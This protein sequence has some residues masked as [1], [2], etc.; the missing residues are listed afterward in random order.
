MKNHKNYFAKFL[1][2]MLGA[3]LAGVSFPAA[4]QSVLE[5]PELLPLQPEKTVSA[6]LQKLDTFGNYQLVQ[7]DG[8][9]VIL[10]KVNRFE[11]DDFNFDESPDF[12][13]IRDQGFNTKADLFVYD[14]KAKKFTLLK[15]PA[16]VQEKMLCPAFSNLAI[17]TG[18]DKKPVALSSSCMARRSTEVHFDYLKYDGDGRLWISQQYRHA[19]LEVPEA[20]L[21]YSDLPWGIT[22]QMTEYSAQGDV[23][24][25]QR[26]SH[27]L[28][29]VVVKI[30]RSGMVLHEEPS[31]SAA[32]LQTL[33]VAQ[34]C[35]LI[36]L[37]AQW[38]KLECSARGK[39]NAGWLDW[40]KAV[41]GKSRPFMITES[42]LVKQY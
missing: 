42:K 17:V 25:E 23:I 22:E 20:L 40:S 34:I 36:D 37:D 13:V 10:E 32:V 11:V 35:Y 8:S 29:P 31:D 39:K 3:C 1:V 33:G 18:A 21:P 6:Q 12:L 4:A 5:G 27:A 30:L 19:P 14:A 7:P 24:R 2:Q 16:E 28:D 41:E 15:P 9:I 26:T 38:M